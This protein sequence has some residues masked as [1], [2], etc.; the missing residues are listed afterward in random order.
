MVAGM[1][2]GVS[3]HSS[4]APLKCGCQQAR[5]KIALQYVYFSLSSVFVFYNL[6]SPST[7][8]TKSVLHLAITHEMLNC[9]S[10]SM[11]GLLTAILRSMRLNE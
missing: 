10:L 6:H 8:H 11:T 7:P 2:P 4:I 3:H 5:Y 1:Q 9:V